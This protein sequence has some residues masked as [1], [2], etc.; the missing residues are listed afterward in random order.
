[1]DAPSE[2]NAGDKSLDAIL[3][4][5]LPETPPEHRRTLLLVLLGAVAIHSLSSEEDRRP[6]WLKDA[7][8]VGGRRAGPW[9]G[10]GSY[11][12]SFGPQTRRR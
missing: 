4:R 6:K 10:K 8:P 1:M 5:A 9:R 2:P 11:G 7:P 12:K 3:A